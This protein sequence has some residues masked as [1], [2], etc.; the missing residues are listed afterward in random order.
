M[1]ELNLLGGVCTHKC[2]LNLFGG[3][4]YPQTPTGI[5]RMPLPRSL[6][7]I[8]EALSSLSSEHACYLSTVNRNLLVFLN[9]CD[10]I[11]SIVFCSM[12]GLFV[13][14]LLITTF[15]ILYTCNSADSD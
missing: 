14:L 15:K 4:L 10:S 5:Y 3:V 11:L 9:S 1:T 8:G 7:T 2:F 6:H 13:I 12:F